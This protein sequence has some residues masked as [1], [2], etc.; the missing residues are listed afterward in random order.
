MDGAKRS[1]EKRDAK[2]AVRL[3]RMLL[4]GRGQDERNVKRGRD[5]EKIIRNT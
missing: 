2:G 3:L 1:E 4:G 5:P